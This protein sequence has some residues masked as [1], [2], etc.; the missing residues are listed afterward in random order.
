MYTR[1]SAKIQS[2]PCLQGKDEAY[3]IEA[4]HIWPLEQGLSQ[5]RCISRVLYILAS[6][7]RAR[8]SPRARRFPGPVIQLSFRGKELDFFSPYSQQ[9]CVNRRLEEFQG[10]A[11][12]SESQM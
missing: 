4:N 5:F 12:Y 7:Q 3:Y 9:E 10:H 8:N 2:V 6:F 11:N 1:A